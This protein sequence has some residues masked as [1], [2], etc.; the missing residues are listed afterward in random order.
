VV[1]VLVTSNINT[2]CLL[3][4]TLFR[5]ENVFNRHHGRGA[6]ASQFRTGVQKNLTE[7]WPYFFPILFNS[8][9]DLRGVLSFS[10]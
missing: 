10:H 9:S 8:S 3:V 2:L 5:I 6:G 1:L 7:I 4:L